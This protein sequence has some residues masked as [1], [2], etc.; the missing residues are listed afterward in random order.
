MGFVLYT[1]SHCI[2]SID[3]ILANLEWFYRAML[4]ISVVYAVM[5]CPS[6]CLSV[7][8]VD[9]V[10]TNTH[11]FEILS[12]SGSHNIIVFRTKWGGDIPTGTPLTGASKARGYE[13]MTIFDQY[14]A[15]S[16]K[17]CNTE[18]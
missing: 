11:I 18:P 9:H 15:L 10:K 1:A 6:V 4:C 3:C 2:S 16:P 5:R 12:P 8:F 13:K 17:C 14:L 7:T